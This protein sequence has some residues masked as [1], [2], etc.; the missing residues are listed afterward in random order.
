MPFALTGIGLLVLAVLGFLGHH[1]TRSFSRMGVWTVI[2]GAICGIVGVGPQLAA[3][4]PDYTAFVAQLATSFMHTAWAT[5]GLVLVVTIG[6]F[7]WRVFAGRLL[8]RR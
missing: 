6:L 7:I 4:Q 5:I 8:S 3:D 2:D 1:F